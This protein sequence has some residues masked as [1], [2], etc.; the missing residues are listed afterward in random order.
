MF[1]TGL[2]LLLVSCII[3]KRSYFDYLI[4]NSPTYDHSDTAHSSTI[5]AVKNNSIVKSDLVES[6]TS[7]SS[8][9]SKTETHCIIKTHNTAS[10][11]ANCKCAYLYPIDSLR[12]VLEILLM[13][14][15][16]PR[17]RI[18]HCCFNIKVRTTLEIVCV[19]YSLAFLIV[20]LSEIIVQKFNVYIR[21]LFSNTTKLLFIL[22]LICVVLIVP[23]RL[24]CNTF[25]EDMLLTGGIALMSAYFIYFARFSILLSHE[26]FLFLN[27]Y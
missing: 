14:V 22:S 18:I 19:L 27:F 8:S 15:S 2:F 16:V 3:L 21:I 25:A 4:S 7:T 12:Y 24:A 5:T 9:S 1:F 6:S 17:F 13:I 20:K 11:S 26:S 23:F 10:L